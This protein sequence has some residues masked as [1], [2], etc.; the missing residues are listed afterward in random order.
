M[1]NSKRPQ[2]E[3]D[4]ISRSK[5]GDEEAYSELIKRYRTRIYFLCFQMLH[6]QELAEDMTQE[7]FIHAYRHLSRFKMESRFYTWVYR[8]AVNLTI[9]L[10]RKKSHQKTTVWDDTS[11]KTESR[12][13]LEHTSSGD[14]PEIHELHEAIEKGMKTL[15]PAHREVLQLFDIEGLSHQEIAKRLKV[16]SGTVR[17]RLYYARKQMQKFLKDFIPNSAGY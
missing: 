6:D 3:P 11:L 15:S 7:T 17:S 4:L 13:Y 9:N 14:S 5:Q 2:D 16:K 1:S 10:I 12:D 8:I